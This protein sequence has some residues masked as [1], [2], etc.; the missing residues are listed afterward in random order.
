MNLQTWRST[1]ACAS[2]VALTSLAAWGADWP[3]FL[4]PQ[5]N[6][7][8]V[9]TGLA[10]SWPAAGPKLLWSAALG[11]GFA[12]PAVSAGQVF[13]LDRP[14]DTKDVLRC[15]GLGDGKELWSLAYDAPG[16]FSIP[17]SRTTPTLTDKAAYIVGPLGHFHCVDRTTHEARWKKHLLDD[18]GGKLPNWGVSQ[19]PV[20]Y[21]DL[22]IVAPQSPTV[23][24]AAFKGD[25]GELAWKSPELGPLSYCSPTL[26]RLGDV[27]QVVLVSAKGTVSGIAA[28]DGRLLWQYKGWSCNIPIASPV[29]IGDGRVFISGEY[30]AGSVMLRIAVADG[31][32]SAQEVFKTQE[33]MSQIHQALLYQGHLYANSNGNKARDGFVCLGLDGKMTWRTGN[34]PNFERGSLLLADG[35]IFTVNGQDGTLAIFEA[36]PTQFKLL[37]S[38]PV[39][40]GKQAWAPLALVDGKLLVRDQKELKCFDVRAAAAP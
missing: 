1:Y 2:V 6:A 26:A 32:F 23:G 30:G 37:A 12:G 36:S 38:A 28:A 18:F 5:R 31:V 4:G 27:D 22:V 13:I 35:M 7:V 33:C 39:L 34:E 11:A 9:E 40:Q 20:L 8:S 21:Q 25:T 19:S 16:T 10:R 14:D 15:Y 24:V 17:G 29:L 3:Q